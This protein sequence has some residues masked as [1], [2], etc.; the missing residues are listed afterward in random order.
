MKTGISLLVAM[1]FIGCSNK[2]SAGISASGTIEGTDVTVAAEV[3]GKVKERHVDEGSR[4]SKGDTLL[5][6]DDTEY[7]IQL[8]FS[9]PP[10]R[11]PYFTHNI[12]AGPDTKERIIATRIC[13]CIQTDR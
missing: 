10:T 12:I 9:L 8:R 7:Q 4:V 5:I 3:A 11:A 2:E 13:R 1:M 6:I